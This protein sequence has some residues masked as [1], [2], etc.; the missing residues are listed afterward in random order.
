MR[1]IVELDL[2]YGSTM[3]V[4]CRVYESRFDFEF[5]RIFEKFSLQRDKNQSKINRNFGFEEIKKEKAKRKDRIWEKPTAIDTKQSQ[6]IC[7]WI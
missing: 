3:D 5:Y 4:W 1:W 6:W 2:G 7:P